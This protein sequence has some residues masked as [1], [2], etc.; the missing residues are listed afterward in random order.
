MLWTRRL[1]DNAAY[2]GTLYAEGKAARLQTKVDAGGEE[3]E[4]RLEVENFPQ[5]VPSIN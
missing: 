4:M 3:F 2:A 5:S 1:A